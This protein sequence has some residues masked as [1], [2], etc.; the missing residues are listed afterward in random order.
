MPR[1][2]ILQYTGQPVQLGD[3]EER[4]REEGGGFFPLVQAAADLA[5]ENAGLTAGP[6]RAQCPAVV[7]NHEAV[8]EQA[9][10]LL[11]M[12][13]HN[14]CGDAI[15]RQSVGAPGLMPALFALGRPAGL[16]ADASGSVMS[17]SSSMFSGSQLRGGGRLPS[18]PGQ[19]PT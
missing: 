11:G 13:H 4:R 2:D 1:A 8:A 10:P 16:G 15:R 12:A 9:P 7:K 5:E 6:W 3:T 19:L 14:V 17:R 18:R